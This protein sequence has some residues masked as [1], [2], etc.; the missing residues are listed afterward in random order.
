MMGGVTEDM[1]NLL[2]SFEGLPIIDKGGYHYFVHPLT[3]GIPSI[4]PELQK[5]VSRLM[6]SLLPG[7]L[8][9]DLI[10]TAEAMGIPLCSCIS[11][12]LGVP[13]SVMRKRSYGMEG[14]VKV[15]Q[16]TGYSYG[17]LYINV[18]NWAKK[19]LIVDDVLS[20]GGTLRGLVEGIRETGRDPV[21]ALIFVDKMKPSKRELLKRALDI[22]I[23]S[24]VHVDIKNGECHARPT[25][26]YLEG[27]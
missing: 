19:A 3:D 27:Q 1:E 25:R 5:R 17:N 12:I 22:E 21:G 6:I 8:E 23:F 24:L 18:P 4:D 26:D 16:E 9:F 2:A 15:G 20:T 7:D 13:Y 10:S 14:E 11:D